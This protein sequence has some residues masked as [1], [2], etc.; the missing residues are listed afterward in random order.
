MTFNYEDKNE[1]LN[2][3]KNSGGSTILLWHVAKLLGKLYERG[4]MP[5]EDYVNDLLARSER[6]YIANEGRLSPSKNFSLTLG[7]VTADLAAIT[8][9]RTTF[10]LVDK[11]GSLVKSVGR[12][13]K[14]DHYKTLVSLQGG[15]ENVG[16][17]SQEP[18]SIARLVCYDGNKIN[19]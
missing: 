17:S 9:V 6:F 12:R 3:D 5:S 2:A 19:K 4:T 16:D 13:F 8:T 11:V 14:R 1:P 18:D 7:Y 15:A 10:G